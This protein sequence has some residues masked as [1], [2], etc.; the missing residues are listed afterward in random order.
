LCHTLTPVSYP[1]TCVRPL[2]LCQTLTP[3]FTNSPD[4][5]NTHAW[6]AL[7]SMASTCSRL[8]WAWWS[9]AASYGQ[10]WESCAV[11]VCAVP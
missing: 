6:L 2:H 5:T 4:S 10:R 8:W 7:M 11:I 3:V 9:C 1:H